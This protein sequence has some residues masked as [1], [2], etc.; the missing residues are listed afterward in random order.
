M[1]TR[2][3]LAAAAIALTTLGCQLLRAPLRPSVPALPEM[4]Q[5]DD[6][7]YRDDVDADPKKHRLDLYLPARAKGDA[8]TPVLVF[9]HGGG[10]R[11]GD[12]DLKQLGVTPYIDIGRFY[13]QHGF[14]VVVP[15][16]RLPPATWRDQ[17][18][19]VA[20][21][22]AWTYRNITAHDGDP[23]RIFVGGHS[24]GAQ[25]ATRVALDRALLHERDADPDA[26]C[27]VLAISGGGYDLADEQTYDLGARR[28][29]YTEIF[30][31]AEW[32]EASPV[33]YLDASA[34]PFLV[35]SARGE[36]PSLHHQN[37]LLADALADAGADARNVAL[38]SGSARVAMAAHISTLLGLVQ[39]DDDADLSDPAVE[40]TSA[41]H[42]LAFLRDGGRCNPI[43][44]AGD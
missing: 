42:A 43:D 3:V 5:I 13:A 21:A 1:P 8:P 11:T 29:Y 12:K 39:L 23:A 17:V 38:T 28:S 27:G 2:L 41:P 14:V 16:Y 37:R 33:T 7:A 15:N 10:W 35:L 24:A 18:D 9:V 19:D 30:P 4:R 26:I 40:G 31:E 20:D 25:L 22:V 44:R 32:T 34:P 36:W 6:V